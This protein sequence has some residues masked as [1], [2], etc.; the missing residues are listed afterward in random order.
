[1]IEEPRCRKWAVHVIQDL[2]SNAQNRMRVNGQYSEEFGARVGVHQ[3]SVF[4]PLLFI[5]VLE[6][7]SREF[8]TGMPRELLYADDLVLIADTQEECISKPKAWKAGMESKGLHVNMK[9]TKLLV[10][11][12]GHDVLKKSGKYPRAFCCSGVGIIS[13]E[14]LQCKLWVLK[15]C[16]GIIG[17]LVVNPNYVMARLGP[18]TAE[19]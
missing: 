7:L 5:L 8:C 13:I 2:Y 9:R 15:R 4:N 14:C 6:M 3:D 18:S 11:D 19:L 16:S 10:S 1:M 12:D 17:Q